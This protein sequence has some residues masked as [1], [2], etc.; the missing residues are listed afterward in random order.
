M[1][2]YGFTKE[3]DIPYEAVIE[4]IREALEKE[5]FGILTEI[6][7][8]AKMKE[9]LGVNMKKYI[10]LGVCNPLSAYKAIVAEENIGLMLPCNVV[11]YE[12]GGKTALSVIRPT[13]AMQMIDNVQLHKLAQAVEGRMKKAFDAVN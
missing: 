13:V 6:D 11:V 2:N 8:R 12:K 10:I 5:G 4:Q 1:T 3:L 7:V 9:K